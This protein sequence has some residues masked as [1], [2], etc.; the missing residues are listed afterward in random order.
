MIGTALAAIGLIALA[1][2][3]RRIALITVVTFA[4]YFFFGLVYNVADVAVFGDSVV[5]IIAIWIGVGISA[6][7]EGAAVRARQ[8]FACF[9]PEGGEPRVDLAVCDPCRF[10]PSPTMMPSTISARAGADA[11]S[12]GWLT[13]SVAHS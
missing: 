11:R 4:G 1:V 3:S 7:V 6:I 5:L 9:T 13:L 10:Y 12:V 8:E 2:R